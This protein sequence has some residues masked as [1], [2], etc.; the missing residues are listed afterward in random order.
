MSSSNLTGSRGPHPSRAVMAGR[1]LSMSE[2]PDFALI[3][4]FLGSLFDPNCGGIDHVDVLEE[5][6]S[7]DRQTATLL[8]RNVI[9]N[10][11]SPEAWQEHVRMLQKAALREGPEREPVSAGTPSPS[12][13]HPSSQH[14]STPPRQTSRSGMASRTASMPPANG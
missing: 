11:Q 4:A 2:Q 12:E 3:Y 6:K 7:I 1:S 10:L 8:M 9:S 5:M 14:F 13:R